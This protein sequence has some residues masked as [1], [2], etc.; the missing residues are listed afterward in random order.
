MGQI[1]SSTARGGSDAPALAHNVER[2]TCAATFGRGCGS[3]DLLWPRRGTLAVLL[4][5]VAGLGF[6]SAS[7]LRG[8]DSLGRIVP[9][10]A[11]FYFHYSLDAEGPLTARLQMLRRALVESGMVRAFRDRLDSSYVEGKVALEKRAAQEVRKPVKE[12]MAKEIEAIS[13]EILRRDL[14][15][16]EWD[17]ILGRLQVWDLISREGILAARVQ[18]GWGQAPGRRQWLLAFRVGTP[19]ERR[20]RLNELREVLTGLAA[21]LPDVEMLSSQRR[22]SEVVVLY[23]I[24]DPSEELCIAGADDLVLLTTARGLLGAPCYFS[25]A[26]EAI[27][28]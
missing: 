11:A 18:P 6:S 13:A 27:W 28:G 1:L 19:M 20:A 2:R 7:P 3:R 21:V 9:S 4:W 17:R 10:D 25:K 24:F 22:G 14:D 26:K 8:N 12:R 16:L 23:N 5:I 15:S